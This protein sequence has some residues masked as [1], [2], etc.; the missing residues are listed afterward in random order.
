MS[1]N[2]NSIKEILKDKK[3]IDILNKRINNKR[4]AHL[5]R[6]ASYLSSKEVKDFNF[7]APPGCHVW[8]APLK[9][10]EE[11]VGKQLA[12]YLE[13]DP[14]MNLQNVEIDPD[15]GHGIYTF[16]CKHKVAPNGAPEQEQYAL[17]Y[18]TDEEHRWLR[19]AQAKGF[20]EG[21]SSQSGYKEGI[22][23]SLEAENEAL[24]KFTEEPKNK[25]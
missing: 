15:T 8:Q 11:L 14:K 2:L 24:R 13:L 5:K 1:G 21:Y 10:A 16:N 23:A 4:E 7:L 25:K 20:K 18:M 6:A 9:Q 12:A 19:D 17:I 3:D 22:D